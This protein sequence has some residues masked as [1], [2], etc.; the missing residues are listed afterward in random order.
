MELTLVPDADAAMAGAAVAVSC[1]ARVIDEA[2]AWSDLIGHVVAR[3]GLGARVL[4][5]A[6]G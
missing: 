1:D 6:A 2:V 4:R 5:L 3:E